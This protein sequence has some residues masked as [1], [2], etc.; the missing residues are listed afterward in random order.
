MKVGL[1]GS[2]RKA[3]LK[4]CLWMNESGESSEGAQ[5]EASLQSKLLEQRLLTAK[6][7]A[8][9]PSKICFL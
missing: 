1:E 7:Y 9:A 8:E 5:D 2:L 4:E 6:A 3:L